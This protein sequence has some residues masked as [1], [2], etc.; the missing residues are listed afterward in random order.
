MCLRVTVKGTGISA[1]NNEVILFDRGTGLTT[2]FQKGALL[3]GVS[4][5]FGPWVIACL[6]TSR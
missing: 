5:E 3:S 2:T 6:L 1:A 4:F